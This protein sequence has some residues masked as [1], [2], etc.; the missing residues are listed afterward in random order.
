MTEREKRAV[1]IYQEFILD[2]GI[3]LKSREEKAFM[4]AID[5]SLASY[6][7]MRVE[8]AEEDIKSFK[9]ALPRFGSHHNVTIVDN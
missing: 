6:N 8:G 5:K 7:S 3:D 4:L 9:R 2:K 1:E